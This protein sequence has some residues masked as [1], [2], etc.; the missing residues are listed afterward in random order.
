MNPLLRKLGVALLA[1]C[2][3]VIGNAIGTVAADTIKE[4]F[5]KQAPT[6]SRKRV[7]R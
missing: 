7:R 5:A 3:G 4:T 2:A 6:P 1:A